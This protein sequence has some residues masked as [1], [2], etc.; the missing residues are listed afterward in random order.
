MSESPTGWNRGHGAGFD[1]WLYFHWAAIDKREW[2][3]SWDV[4]VVNLNCAEGAD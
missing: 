1:W 3:V 2:W 4:G